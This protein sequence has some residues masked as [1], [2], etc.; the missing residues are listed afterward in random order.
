ME[1]RVIKIGLMGLGTVGTGVAKIL[2]N[3]A[4]VLERRIGARLELVKVLERYKARAEG[5]LP[6]ELL[7]EDPRELTENPEVDVVVELIGGIHP[8]KEFILQALQNGKSVVTANKDLIAQEGKELFEMAESTNSDLLFEASVGGGIPI[9]RP[10]K[11]CLAANNIKTV[12]GIVNGT[13]NYML[14]KMTQEGSDFAEVLAEA[15]ARGYAESDPTADVGGL[16]AARKVAILA[17][18]AFNTRVTFDDVYVE[19]I[20]KVTSQDI[21]YATELGYII[22]LLGIAKLDEEG[23]VEVR[24]HPTFIPKNHPMAS[25]NDVFNAIFVNGDAVGDTMFYGRGAGEM[26]T[27]SAVV[28]DVM[29][30]AFNIVRN[31]KGRMPCTCYENRKFKKQ[32]DR[33][34]KFYVRV[35]AADRPGVLASIAKAF[36][37]QGVSLQSVIQKDNVG[38]NATV[39]LVTHC[40]KE[41]R[42]LEAL[43]TLEGMDTVENIGNVIR[44][45]GDE[46]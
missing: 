22:K 23:Q 25:V 5:L 24:V 37:D 39:V 43:K 26:P 15:Q 38:E 42:I 33:V 16:D 14:T 19:G 17:S 12:M 13:T 7:T 27:A 34:S 45:E 30:A 8:A 41:G 31:D 36:G 9:I 46:N 10:L 11:Q 29:E 44:V 3:N 2:L 35:L 4:D 1:K 32:E 21:T 18:I 28:G 20:T 40:T 6:L